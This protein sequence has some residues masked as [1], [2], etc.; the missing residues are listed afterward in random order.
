MT[1][2]EWKSAHSS[3][4]FQ[5]HNK[6]KDYSIYFNSQTHTTTMTQI[7]DKFVSVLERE[8]HIETGKSLTFEHSASRDAHSISIQNWNTR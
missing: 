6:F 7:N 1:K 5:K 8:L 4:Q 2:I 3:I